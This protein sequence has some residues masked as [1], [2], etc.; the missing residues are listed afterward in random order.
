MYIPSAFEITDPVKLEE[1]ISSNSFATL[2]SKDG[3]SFFA[4]HLPFLYK[5]GQG[6]KGK[7]MSHMARA[8]RHWKLF[9]EKEEAFVIF[10]GPHAYISP[11][12]YET[13]V[14]VPTWNYATVH[15]YGFPKLIETDEGL[16]NI[17][18]E[19]VEKHESGRPD[20]WTINLPPEMKSNMKK[21]IV[22]FE[23]GIT[24]MEG[25]FKLGQNRPR[26]DREKMLRMLLESGDS[27]SIRLA[28]LMQR[29]MQG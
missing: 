28:K 20:P 9:H 3:D 1:I 10:A 19:T 15:V 27:E 12:W 14:A 13:E 24:R 16:D 23:I 11:R 29:E 2:V 26:E 5:P 17:L 18:N 25:K 4:S 8:N 21:A 22:G 6:G 7:L